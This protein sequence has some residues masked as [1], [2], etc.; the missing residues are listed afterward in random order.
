MPVLRLHSWNSFLAYIHT[1]PISLTSDEHLRKS[2]IIISEK[3]DLRKEYRSAQEMKRA[4]KQMHGSSV[5]T[6]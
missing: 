3:I 4:L 1:P 5:S 2:T 6:P